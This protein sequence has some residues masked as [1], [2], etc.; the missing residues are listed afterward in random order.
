MLDPLRSDTRFGAL[1]RQYDKA[2]LL[3][4]PGT[5]TEAVR[6]IAVLPF[7]PLGQ[8][9]NGELLGLG[10]ADAIIG[11]MSNLKQLTVLP[12]SAVWKQ[13]RL[14]RMQPIDRCGLHCH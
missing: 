14:R 3:E 12:T 1:L 4:G 2:S 8:D 5:A 6:S 13:N 9:T 7:E 11:R 10:M